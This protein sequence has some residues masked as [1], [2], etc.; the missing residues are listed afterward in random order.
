M[1]TVALALAPPLRSAVTFPPFFLPPHYG[2]LDAVFDP[3]AM[4][5]G[6]CCQLIADIAFLRHMVVTRKEQVQLFGALPSL[7]AKLHDLTPS[8]QQL[9]QASV[10]TKEFFCSVEL[11]SLAAT[12]NCGNQKWQKQQKR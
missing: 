2:T 8:P 6:T 12:L 7:E 3:P 9:P 1:A 4:I 10:K 11:D 5:S